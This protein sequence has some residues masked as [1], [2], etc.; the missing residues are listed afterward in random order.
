MPVRSKHEE[1]EDENVPNSGNESSE[2]NGE[3]AWEKIANAKT[4]GKSAED[5]NGFNKMNTNF[6]IMEDEEA[7]IVFLSENP[8]IFWG[9]GLKLFSKKSGKHYYSTEAC[10]KSKQSHCVLCSSPNANVG[11]A[12]QFV[13]FPILD[14][15]GSWDS[16]AKGFDGTP[17][18][19][20]FLVSIGLAKII[21]KFKDE[22]GGTLTDK[23]VK[24]SKNGKNYSFLP[25]T[26]KNGKTLTFLDPPEYDGG[27]PEV[28]KI[29]GVSNDKYLSLIAGE[30]EVEETT[31]APAKAKGRF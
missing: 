25:R 26:E 6:F 22:M 4:G 1:A 30:A 28:E 10:Q 27:I 14:S 3:D 8:Y 2:D 5:A 23:V 16:K 24:L 18:A 17:V 20:I 29:Y 19:K 15:R 13:A 21:K 12:R 31:K 9:H 11:E 7:D